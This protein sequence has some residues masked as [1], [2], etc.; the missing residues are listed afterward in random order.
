LASEAGGNRPYG[1]LIR[2][3]AFRKTSEFEARRHKMR[4]VGFWPNPDTH[5]A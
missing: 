3:P 2:L 1:G 4:I 5:D